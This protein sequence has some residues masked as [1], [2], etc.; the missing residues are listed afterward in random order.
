MI[1]HTH[2]SLPIMTGSEDYT[3]AHWFQGR[4]ARLRRLHWDESAERET[5]H[6]SMD[7]TGE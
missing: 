3:Q 2:Q 4:K 5:K 7:A 1:T 6:V